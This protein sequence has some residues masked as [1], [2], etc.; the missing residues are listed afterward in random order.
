VKENEGG[1]EG[2]LE[3]KER[4]EA[5]RAHERARER[6]R[7]GEIETAYGGIISHILCI[8]QH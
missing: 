6:A 4:G 8:Q 2:K 5:E 7:L 1:K 3:A